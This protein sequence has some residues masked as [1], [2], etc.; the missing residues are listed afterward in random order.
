MKKI[1]LIIMWVITLISMGYSYYLVND[2][3]YWSSL[4]SQIDVVPQATNMMVII[5]TITTP[6]MIATMKKEK[7][8]GEVK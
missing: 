8:K 4:H 2:V 7:E 3:P 1:V 5:S 6:I